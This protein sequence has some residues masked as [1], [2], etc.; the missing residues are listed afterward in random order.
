MSLAAMIMASG[1]FAAL[2]SNIFAIISN[3]KQQSKR[4]DFDSIHAHII[5]TVDFE[6][7]TKGN[8]EERM[9]SLISD[10]KVINKSN[11]NKDSYWIKVDLAD[12]TTKS[13]LHFSHDSLP[14]SPTAGNVDLLFSTRSPLELT[15]NG[16]RRIEY[17]PRSS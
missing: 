3:S 10:G 14:N 7:F 1:E 13:N 6:D 16:R 5:K 12:I 15:G 11:R 9:N 8:L 2:D 4:A 17:Y